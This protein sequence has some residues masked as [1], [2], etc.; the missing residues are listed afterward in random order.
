MQRCV[1][2]RIEPKVFSPL[3]LALKASIN[4]CCIVRPSHTNPIHQILERLGA[5]VHAKARETYA[6]LYSSE[7]GGIVTD[8]AFMVIHMD[9]HIVHRGHGVFDTALLCDGYL[10][11]LDQHLDRFLRSAERAHIHLPYS[12][13]KLRRIIL[14]TAAASKAWNGEVR[15]WA[16]AGR[17]GF[18]LTT[19]ECIAPTFYVQVV[20]R[21]ERKAVDLQ[22][23]AFKVKTTPVAAKPPFFA[24][25]KSVNYLP[26]ALNLKDA[27]DSG[28]DQGIFVDAEGNIAEGPN[29]NV[30]IVTAEDDLVTPPFEAALDGI[31]VQRALE[32]AR[33]AREGKLPAGDEGEEIR[34]LRKIEQRTVTA[35]DI[36]TAKEI[37]MVGSS[38]QVFP[39]LEWDKAR[40]GGGKVG[41][42]CLTLRSLILRDM[43]TPGAEHHA[44]VP[45]GALTNMV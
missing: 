32:L 29:M 19:K 41:P 18:G 7:L 39:V 2:E 33:L 26:N 40:V 13:S 10:Y 20:N 12:R 22:T 9:D 38:V 17:G 37:M 15:Y 34:H 8:P 5:S 11:Q 3:F 23:E 16:S 35:E 36:R 6:S 27:E 1:L 25:V 31:T 24:T 42:V 44:E 45:Y 43:Y 4:D 21:R 14:D 30:L 28:V